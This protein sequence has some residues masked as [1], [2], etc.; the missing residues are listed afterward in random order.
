MKP[1][2]WLDIVDDDD[3]V[4]GR[5][6]RDV[7]HR[8]GHMHRAVHIMVS[9]SQGLWFVQKRSANKDTNPGLWDTSAAGHVDSGESYQ[10]CA[11][12]EL[13]EE[14]GIVVDEGALVSCGRLKPLE[15]TGFEFVELF[16][17]I[18]DQPLT[19]EVEEISDGRWLD[20]EALHGWMCSNPH[21]FTSVFHTVW[22]LAGPEAPAP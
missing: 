9:N 17:V 3:V 2:E 22:D 15:E 12:R 1:I 7:I 21:E 6:P 5:A 13:Q 20:P 18:S 4:V 16:R 10:A 19:L 14:L 11:V 8:E